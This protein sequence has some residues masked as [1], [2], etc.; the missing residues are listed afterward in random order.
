MP[1]QHYRFLIGVYTSTFRTILLFLTGGL[2]RVLTIKK[3]IGIQILFLQ[4]IALLN[5]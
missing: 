2:Q 1:R 3:G 4:I 5:Q